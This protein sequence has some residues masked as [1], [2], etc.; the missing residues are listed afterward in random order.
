MFAV[1]LQNVGVNGGNPPRSFLLTGFEFNKSNGP[2]PKRAVVFPIRADFAAH[3]EATIATDANA[4]WIFV[5]DQLDTHRSATLVELVAR[6][7]GL[8]EPL[9]IKGK[10]GI[11]KSKQTRR[12]FLQ[13]PTHQICFVY[14]PRHCSWLNQVEIWFSILARRLLKRA[15]F[16]SLDD[17]R[18]RVL[19]F[20]SYF[21]DVLG[22]PFRWT[23]T[24]RPLQA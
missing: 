9:G 5:A 6:H 14:T 8:D 4:R 21:N 15:S 19:D 3:I 13:D 12:A 2:R 22:K 20:I 17:L 7:C 1:A 24:G 23:Y 10:T 18:T 16:T 11:L